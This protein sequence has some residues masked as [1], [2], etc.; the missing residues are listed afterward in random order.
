MILLMGTSDPPPSK[1]LPHKNITYGVSD[2]PSSVDP[3]PA[4]CGDE[5]I[6]AVVAEKKPIVSLVSQF[7][8]PRVPIP[9]GKL[10]K[11]TVLEVF[12]DVHT[13]LGT[14]CQPLHIFVNPNVTPVQAHPIGALQL[15]SP[16]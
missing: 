6:A 13:R 14:L 8:V 2:L 11:A 5:S 7:S 16:K 4:N 12:K 1:T 15:K 10:A 3:V 9:W